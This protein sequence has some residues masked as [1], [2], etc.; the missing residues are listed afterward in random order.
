MRYGAN[1]MRI[2]VKSV[3]LLVFDEMWHPFYVFQY[4]SVMIWC[5]GDSSRHHILQR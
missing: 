3:A 2:P 5:A 1:E 4:F